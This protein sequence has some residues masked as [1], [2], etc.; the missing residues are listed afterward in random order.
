[1]T[2]LRTFAFLLAAASLSA[3]ATPNSVTRTAPPVLPEAAE[4]VAVPE[5]GTGIAVPQITAPVRIDAVVVNVPRT[6]EVSEANR[7]LPKGDIVWRGDAPGDRHAQV[8]AIFEEAMLRGAQAFDG[9]RSVELLIEVTRFHALSE[10]ARYT[11]GG[12]HNIEFTMALA[13]PDTGEIVAPWRAVVADLDGFGGDAAI[14]AERIGQ[15]QKV[16]ITDH[17][18]RV[19]REEVSL[20]EGHQTARLGL[21]QMLN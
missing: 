4:R 7:Y 13:D 9:P 15:T 21:I 5:A 10:K 18:A 14:E 11:T 2:I 8:Q 1:M 16:R 20:P 6:L 3:C 12:V 17:L 19:L